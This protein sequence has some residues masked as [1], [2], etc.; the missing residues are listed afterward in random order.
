LE[1]IGAEH[2]ADVIKSNT[3]IDFHW[4]FNYWKYVFRVSWTW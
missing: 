1:T 4:I 2:L 3:V